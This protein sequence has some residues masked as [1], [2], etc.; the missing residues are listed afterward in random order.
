MA[1]L[2]HIQPLSMG[3]TCQLPVLTP[4]TDGATHIGFRS[5]IAILALNGG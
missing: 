1:I 2:V 5:Y 3:N 4:N